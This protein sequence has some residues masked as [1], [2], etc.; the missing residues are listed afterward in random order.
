M[1]VIKR[2][3]TEVDFDILKIENAVAKA[4]AAVN[5]DERM[6]ALQ[7]KRIA[8]AVA[9]SCQSMNRALGVEEIQDLV[10]RQIMAH[11]AFEV[12]KEYITYRYNRTLIRQSNTTDDRIMSLI[13]CNNEEAKKENSIKNPTV[14]SVQRYYM[15][16]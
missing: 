1:K 16:G 8:E 12:A 13:E 4:N 10:E 5:E 9:I 14:I 3:G 6:T 15:A 11:G 7:V 2:S